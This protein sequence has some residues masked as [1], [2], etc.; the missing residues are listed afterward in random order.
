MGVCFPIDIIQPGRMNEVT[1]SHQNDD[2]PLLHKL[3]GSLPMRSTRV[4]CPKHCQLPTIVRLLSNTCSQDEIHFSRREFKRL[5]GNF[6]FQT[7]MGKLNDATLSL[8]LM[9]EEG[10]RILKKLKTVT[11]VK[12]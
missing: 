3:R 9:N 6:H 7:L 4:L 1:F 5:V 11:Y 8:I 12:L 2:D 10:F